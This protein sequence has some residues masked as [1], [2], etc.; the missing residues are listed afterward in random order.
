MSVDY[1]VLESNIIKSCRS[2]NGSTKFLVSYDKLSTLCDDIG[3]TVVEANL[4]SIPLTTN[5]IPYVQEYFKAKRLSWMSDTKQIT[6]L[7]FV[8]TD[9]IDETCQ[10]LLTD[11][12]G[13]RVDDPDLDRVKSM[14]TLL[15][16]YPCYFAT[17]VS[18][19]SNDIKRNGKTT[20]V[21][22][23]RANTVAI[24]QDNYEYH[25]EDI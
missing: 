25:H 4:Q 24:K 13:S 14:A 6:T 16:D 1:K 12:Q 21:I 23:C 9:A 3:M 19:I 2:H 5:L 20:Y 11:L 17:V 8:P 18:Y 15:A 10:S 7:I 22:K